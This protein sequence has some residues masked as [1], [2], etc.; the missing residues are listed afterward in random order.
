MTAS[1][2]DLAELIL[3]RRKLHRMPEVSGDEKETAAEVVRFLS[4]CIPDDI[5]T[6]LG[7]HGV[8]AIFR[9]HEPGPT[10]MFRAELDALPIQ[11]ISKIPHRSERSGKGHMCG[12][13]GHMAMLAAMAR[14]FKRERPQT[15]RVVLLFQ[16]AEE[17]GAGA[18]AVLADPKF[19]P[20]TP[21]FAF[22]LHNLP[23]LP[24]GHSWIKA[25]PA[26][27]ASCGLKISFSGK[28][29]HASQPDKGISP[30]PAIADLIPALSSLSSGSIETEDLVLLTITHAKIGEASFGIAPGD[31][32]LWVTLR[33]VTDGGMAQLKNRVETMALEAATRHG[34]TTSFSYEDEFY[35]SANDEEAVQIIRRAMDDEDL[36]HE[37]GLIF[38]ASED[39]G[40][41]GAVSKS[42]MFFLGSGGN[43]PALHNPD[44]DFPDALIP[45]GSRIFLRIAKNLLG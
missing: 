11:E 43:Q 9:A 1:D 23:G 36:P 29:A 28:T 19:A 2:T 33:T 41:F 13:D 38:R 32:E 4:T 31:G 27:C 6:E 30:A 25:G 17:T 14:H 16:P 7:G 12:H 18:A 8:A 34:L 44:Y 21:D 42:A 35:Y 40:R 15:G 39:F 10:V 26:A 20:I 22:S 3:W 5:I 45:V 24:L 37:D